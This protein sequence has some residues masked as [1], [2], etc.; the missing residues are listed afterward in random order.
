MT[1]WIYLAIA[2]LAAVAGMAAAWFAARWYGQWTFEPEDEQ[3]QFARDTLQ[4]LQDLTRTVKADVDE[5]STCVEEINAQLSESLDA[6]DESVLEAVSDLIEANRRMQRQLDTAEERLQAQ[7][8]QIESHAV[9]AR[10]DP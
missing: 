10:T 2:V 1:S 5:H 8:R 9:E 3:D 6:E 7:A 4:R